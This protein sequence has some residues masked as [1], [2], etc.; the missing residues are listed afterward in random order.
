MT[1]SLVGNL[2]V[3]S[4]SEVLDFSSIDSLEL[5]ELKKGYHKDEC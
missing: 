1:F 4:V 2:G 3:D 5:L